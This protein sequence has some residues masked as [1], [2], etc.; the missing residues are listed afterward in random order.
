[1]SYRC[2]WCGVVFEDKEEAER[3]AISCGIKYEIK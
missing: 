2:K 1:M 3:H